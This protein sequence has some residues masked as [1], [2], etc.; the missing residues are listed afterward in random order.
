VLYKKI[1]IIIPLS[2]VMRVGIYMPYMRDALFLKILMYSLTDS[3]ETIFIAA[4]Y[5]RC[6]SFDPIPVKRGELFD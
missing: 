1:Q 4:G 3:D 2:I 6:P 5:I